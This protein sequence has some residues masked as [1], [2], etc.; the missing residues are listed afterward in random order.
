MLDVKYI[1]CN[2]GS[3]IVVRAKQNYEGHEYM[4]EDTN[5][6]YYGHS[7]YERY[8]KD[9]EGQEWD[10]DMTNEQHRYN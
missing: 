1:P 2:E 7:G 4:R 9:M 5:R 6:V 10:F 3:T 8:Y